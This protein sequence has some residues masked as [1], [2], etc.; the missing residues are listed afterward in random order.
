MCNEQMDLIFELK[1]ENAKLRKEGIKQSKEID[2][3]NAT[4][5]YLE[6]FIEFCNNCGNPDDDCLCT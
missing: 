4:I 2:Q 5:D 3:L 1:R 6:S